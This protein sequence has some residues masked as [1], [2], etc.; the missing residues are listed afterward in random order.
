MRAPS[1]YLGG[2]SG[3]PGPGP[4]LGWLFALL[5]LVGLGVVGVVGVGVVVV[6]VGVVVEGMMNEEVVVVAA[7]VVVA[8]VEESL[9]T[10]SSTPVS[11]ILLDMFVCVFVC[12]CVR[13]YSK[14]K[15]F[16]PLLCKRLNHTA[17][18]WKKWSQIQAAICCV[19]V[20]L[21][22]RESTIVGSQAANKKVGF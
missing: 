8:A 3:G 11:S 9:P 1:L 13:V 18:W 5:L 10:F 22:C 7:A 20:C 12:V 2:G 15:G 4:G 16:F 21:E 19:C 17:Q 6:V 14:Q